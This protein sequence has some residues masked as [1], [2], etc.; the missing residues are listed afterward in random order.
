M[1]YA[2]VSAPASEPLT[3]QEVKVHLKVGPSDGSGTHPDDALITGLIVAARQFAETETRRSLITQTWKLTLDGFPA[4]CSDTPWGREFSIPDAAILL[5]KGPIT[6]ISSITYVDMASQQQT[7]PSSDYIADLTGEL[8]R[9]TPVFGKVWPPTLPQ[10]ASAAV[11]FTA[12]YGN[13]AAVPD[14][15][16]AWMKLR[17]GALYENRAEGS[18]VL[19]TPL[20]FVDRL[21]DPFRIVVA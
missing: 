4:G 14:G 19:F 3:L 5:E 2:L 20:P 13:A 17:I 16:K 6:A 21:L 8:A 11:T 15:I 9:I 1:G 7:M 18:E 10:I 12:G